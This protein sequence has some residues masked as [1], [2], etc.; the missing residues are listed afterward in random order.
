MG[1]WYVDEG[2][3]TLIN[4]WKRKF[5]HAVVGT[6]GDT[7]HQN[8]DSEHNP[9]PQG[10]LPGQD[11]GEV[12][13]GD[14]MIGNGVTKADLQELRDDLVAHRDGRLWYVIWDHHITSSTTQPWVERTYHGSDPHTNHVHVSVNDK[15]DDNESEWNLGAL[16]ARTLQFETVEAAKL[17][18]LQLGDDDDMWGGWNHVARAQALAN[19]LDNKVADVDT[20]GVY[21]AKSAAKFKSLFGGDGKHLSGANMRTLHGI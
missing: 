15:Y 1:S 16:V 9:E 6:I 13:A 19:W 18:L 14:F 10:P 17:P 2:L 7:A 11:K 5:P 8:E 21:G 3:Q 20:D 4:E 12:D